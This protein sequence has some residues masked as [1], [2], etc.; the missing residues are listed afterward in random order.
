M[1]TRSRINIHIVAP[2]LLGSL[3]GERSSGAGII[4]ASIADS[5][6]LRRDGCF[7]K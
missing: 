5:P 7:P 4:P 6:K 1:V 2:D 3:S